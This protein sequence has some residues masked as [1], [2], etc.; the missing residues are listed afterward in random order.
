M[1]AYSTLVIGDSPFHYWR[2]N[3]SAGGYLQDSHAVTKRPLIAQGQQIGTGYS[4]PVSD[5]GSCLTDAN[6]GF[7]YYDTEVLTNPLTV[8]CWFWQT[9]Y[10]GLVQRILTFNTA[11]AVSAVVFGTDATGHFQCFGSASSFTSAAPIDSSKWHYAAATFDGTNM[12]TY[13]DGSLVDTRANAG[14]SLACRYIV[15]TAAANGNPMAG[16]VSEVAIYAATLST[17]QLAAH[18][19]AADQVGIN[20]TNQSQQTGGSTLPPPFGPAIADIRNAVIR[21]A[22]IP[23]QP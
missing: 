4:G 13:L 17:A 2:C 9:Y 14:F 21:T 22:T 23:G 10:Q 11:A 5:G 6:F 8:E 15:G 1:S 20:P 19:A 7:A 12:R 16:S 18:Y 3:D